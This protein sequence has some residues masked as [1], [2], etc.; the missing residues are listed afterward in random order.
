MSEEDGQQNIF[1]EMDVSGD[2]VNDMNAEEMEAEIKRLVNQESE[3]QHETALQQQK[4]KILH[5]RARAFE[6]KKNLHEEKANERDIFAH[7]SYCKRTVT[8]S[9][10]STS[11]AMTSGLGGFP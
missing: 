7:I 9:T 5:M 11:G 4:N 10:S 6:L 2:L 8:D 3:I 1:G